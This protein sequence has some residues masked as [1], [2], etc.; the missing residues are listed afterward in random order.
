MGTS[1]LSL[2]ALG[3]L[4]AGCATP[5]SPNPSLPE[6]SKAVPAR[7][8]DPVRPPAPEPAKTAPPA[9]VGRTPIVVDLSKVKWGEG[10]ADLFGYDDGEMRL[11]FFANGT[12]EFTVKI[13]AEGEYE[14]VL[15]ASCTAALNVN[16]KFKMAVDGQP[17]GTETT[18]TA[19][20]A[21]EYAFGSR[22]A[23]GDRK[24]AISFTNDVYKE[25]E[26]DR[27]FFLNA[28]KLVRAK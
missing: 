4:L 3:L 10:P 6:P 2:A 11:F 22:M 24:V 9:P 16:A 8:A 5:A 28:L 15:T 12:A 13:P 7:P 27:N 21:K 25:N 18:C 14:I 19:E 26:Y 23:A 1:T 17:V 20:E